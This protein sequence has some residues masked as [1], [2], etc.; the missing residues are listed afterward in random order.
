MFSFLPSKCASEPQPTAK[1]KFLI[2]AVFDVI[3]LVTALYAYQLTRLASIDLMSVFGIS[4]ATVLSILFLR[5]R[6]SWLHYV[7]LALSLVG[8]V[9]TVW[10]DLYD[11]SGHINF[12]SFWGDLL[13]IFS[14][15]SYA[16]SNVIQEKLLSEGTRLFA[17]LGNIGMLNSA[18]TLVFF[19]AF[20]EFFVLAHF[21]ESPF[22][23]FYYPAY[24]FNAVVNY[25]LIGLFVAKVGATPYNIVSL[26]TVLWSMLADV[27]VFG[28]PFVSPP[29]P[30]PSQKYL[31]VVGFACITAGVVLFH[32]R[33][34]I[35]KRASPARDAVSLIT[36]DGVPSD[37]GRAGD[38]YLGDREIM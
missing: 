30:S 37:I 23:L 24:V 31:C 21:D 32:I 7:G 11:E 20:T 10:S 1:W 34:P 3:G 19:L 4:V 14:S 2:C 27:F 26:S 28:K 36:S 5:L 8:I 13:A 38:K 15:I 6:Y 18:L 33:K 29:S 25:I 22:F 17:Y 12:G 35:V 9:I 16:V